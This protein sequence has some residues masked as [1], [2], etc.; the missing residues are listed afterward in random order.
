M[1]RIGPARVD[2]VLLRARR[3]CSRQSE[4]SRKPVL[5]S[6]SSVGGRTVGGA[7]G[8]G[9]DHCFAGSHLRCLFN[10]PASHPDGAEPALQS[11]SDI[12]RRGRTGLPSDGELVVD[13]RDIARRDHVRDLRCF[14]V[15][16]RHRRVRDDAGHH[17]SALSRRG[18]SLELAADCCGCGH[19]VLQR[20]RGHL[21]GVELAE[22]RSRRLVSP[23][24]RRRDRDPDVVLARVRWR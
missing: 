20:D 1:V 18:A 5:Q 8:A 17:D 23:S 22:D 11:R 24:G 16:L 21:P 14:R 2:P 10:D 15:R 13:G 9:D 3:A 7:C 6:C 4:S 19:W 12:E